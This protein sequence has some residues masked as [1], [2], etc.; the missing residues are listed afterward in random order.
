MHS[1]LSPA[2]CVRAASRMKGGFLMNTEGRFWS[3]VDKNGPDGCWIWTGAI[4]S[5]GYGHLAVKGKT[6]LSHRF[7]Y[8]LLAGPIPEDEESDHLCRNH[9][10]VNP[11]HI[12]LVTHQENCQRGD[13]RRIVQ[14]Q[15]AKTHCPYG[16]PYNLLNT[17]F[18]PDGRRSCRICNHESKR[19]SRRNESS[20]R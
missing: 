18:R 7:A 10:C 16:H 20:R 19:R 13:H 4:Q 6:V 12:E 8:E 15:R 9:A 14:H 5:A 1:R 11:G 2:R 17:Y 3:K